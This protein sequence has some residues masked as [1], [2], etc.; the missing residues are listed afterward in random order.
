V[1]LPCT[2]APR[3]AAA[4]AEYLAG[5]P[6]DSLNAKFPDLI[7][8]DSKLTVAAVI[9]TLQ[10]SVD[11]TFIDLCRLCHRDLTSR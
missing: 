1:A 2:A 4:G 10:P 3:S 7:D 6:D 8:I 11:V 9:H 5:G